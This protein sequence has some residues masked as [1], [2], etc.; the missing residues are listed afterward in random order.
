[1]QAEAIKSEGLQPYSRHIADL[2]DVPPEL[3]E[4]PIWCAWRLVPKP[5]K[6]P[7]KVPVSPATGGS[8]WRKDKATFCTTAEQAIHYAESRRDLHGVGFILYDDAD[9]G[10]IGGDI[11]HCIDTE[12][13]ELSDPARE[14]IEQADMYTE[15]SPGLNGFR[16]I[17]RGTF[18]GYTGNSQADGVELYEGGRFLTFTGN[19]WEGSPF[20]IENRDLTELGRQYFDR[21][22]SPEKAP[23]SAPEGDRISLQQMALLLAC[24]P[25]Q[26]QGQGYDEF[27]KIA[28]AI[29]YETGE[30][31]DGFTLFNN[32][33]KQSE[34][35]DAEKARTTYFSFTHDGE[36]VTT[37]KTLY[38]LAMDE[39]RK[40]E[41]EKDFSDS[42][43]A[44]DDPF[45]LKAASVA[46][47]LVTDPPERR[48]LVNDRLPLGVVGLLAA[49]GGTG[50]SMATLQLAVSV[51]TGLEWLEM[52]IGEPGAVLMFSGEDDR[53]E[54]HRRLK[55][56]VEMYADTIDPF[57]NAAFQ[58]YRDKIAER[59]YVFD[60]VGKDNRLTAKMNGELH[61]T[62][63]VRR[64]IEVAEQVPECKLIVLD[65]LARFDGGD[66]NDNADS[67]RLVEC[68]EEIRKATGATVLLPHHVSKASMKDNASG[69]EAVRG[70]S[71]LV[72]G[73]RW[74][75]LLSTMRADTAEKEYGIDP[76]EAAKLV[77]FTTPKANY[78][79]PWEGV[80]LRRV[81]GGA[82]VPTIVE[83]AESKTDKKAEERYQAFLVIARDLIKKKQEK[84]EYLTPRK[85]RD[86]AGREGVFGIGEQSLRSCVTRALENGE[87]FQREDG[88][89]R[90]F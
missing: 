48:W 9:H 63:F 76:E 18:G 65:P 53:E 11:D 20:A 79:A 82:L 78:S 85:M 54:I 64:V 21:K 44:N 29:S 89:L 72:D 35:Y 90:L 26:G 52:P 71:G 75:G 33:C 45:D 60:C 30:S 58:P 81:A 61:R 39:L 62:A 14:I 43:A 27:Q 3:A 70:G 8:A 38:F 37:G 41:A 24:I 6:K 17:A 10:I 5:G 4:L 36:K 2:Q 55:A 22:E 15:V 80:W 88:T 42:A 47:L 46:E 32:W 66:P 59:L 19:H 7:D 77:R 28:A 13:G 51:A 69:Q 25:N 31:Q 87:L 34:K 57:D 86:Y 1:M 83:K 23:E 16:F 12:T 40:L 49:A 50:K 73:S 56:V 67:T 74:V 84:G 68:A